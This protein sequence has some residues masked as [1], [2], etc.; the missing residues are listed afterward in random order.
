MSAMK[1][2]GDTHDY[3]MIIEEELS[4]LDAFRRS[5]QIGNGLMEV[6]GKKMEMEP[7]I[8]SPDKILVPTV[9]IKYAP[10]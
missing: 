3:S 9:Y 10:V 8:I 7:T 4:E 6:S 2:E 5:Q 1:E